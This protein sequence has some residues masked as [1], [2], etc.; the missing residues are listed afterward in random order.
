MSPQL[1]P[2]PLSLRIYGHNQPLHSYHNPYAT[3]DEDDP[4]VLFVEG[5]DLENKEKNNN[6]ALEVIRSSADQRIQHIRVHG[7]LADAFSAMNNYEDL[8][9]EIGMGPKSPNETVVVGQE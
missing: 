1:C 7:N 8:N 4:N 5:I 6:E 9:S 2:V 3:Y